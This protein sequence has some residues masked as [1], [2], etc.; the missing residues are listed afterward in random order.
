MNLDRTAQ[1]AASFVAALSPRR[2][3]L[4]QYPGV[5][6][7]Q[8]GPDSFDF[9]PDDSR[10]PGVSGVP[11]RL[12]T[13][14]FTVTVDPAQ[15]PRALL[16]FAGG[17][18][19]RP[20]LHLWE[21]AGLQQLAVSASESISIDARA[22]NLGDAEAAVGRVGDAVDVPMAATA[23]TAWLAAVGTFTGA[24]PFPGG[25][26]IASGSNKVKA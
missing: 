11:L 13:P 22:V 18:P 4:A 1:G 17:D 25:F 26:Q 21:R 9:Q 6:V 16:A 20:E 19:S 3:Y 5:V 24:G 14:G 8:G 2:L 15:R 23:L 10:L 7:A 12:P